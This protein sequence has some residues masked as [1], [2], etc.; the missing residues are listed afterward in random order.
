[1]AQTKQSL[2]SLLPYNNKICVNLCDL[3][4]KKIIHLWEKKII[5]V[6]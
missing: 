3:W 1:M 6:S 5:S 4:E 2:A